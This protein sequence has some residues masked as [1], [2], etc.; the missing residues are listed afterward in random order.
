MHMRTPDDWFEIYIIA[1]LR[2][3]SILI[4]IYRPEK[5]S[6]YFSS[7]DIGFIVRFRNRELDFLGEM[8]KMI[9]FICKYRIAPKGRLRE[10]AAI[11]L[12]W[13]TSLS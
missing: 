12:K 4:N 2:T 13:K 8:S 7:R 5:S 11:R 6:G 10:N 3:A 9:S 1:Y